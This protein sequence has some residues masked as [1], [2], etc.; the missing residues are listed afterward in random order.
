MDIR[1]LRY[2]LAVAQEGQF[3]KAAERLNMAQPPLS[4][5]IKLLEEELGVTLFKRGGKYIELTDAGQVLVVRGEQIL[6]LVNS[7]QKAL[8]DLGKG[9][10]GTV[11]IGTVSSC[12]T[13]LLPK[14][15]SSFQEKFP[16]VTFRIW[17]GDTHRIMDLVNKGI[18]EIG[19]VRTPFKLEIYNYMFHSAVEKNDPMVILYAGKWER[20]IPEGPITLEAL[21]DVPLIVHRRY[22]KI[23]AD[24]CRKLCFEPNIF[25]EGDDTRSIMSWA[26]IGLGVAIVPKPSASIFE[27]GKMRCREIEDHS[28]ETRT[29]VIW[30]K[31]TY[32]SAVSKNF[33]KTIE[34][35]DGN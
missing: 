35:L 31:N 27:T 11:S 25:C 21:K 15:I 28:L 32:L 8:E 16:G 19:I 1:Q 23:I 14:Y 5:Q 6:E 30:L 20:F 13:F 29:A 4:Q 12:G 18:V 33:I 24:N 26:G 7:T 17:E 34:S 3:T 22:Q 2:F 10:Q 9:K